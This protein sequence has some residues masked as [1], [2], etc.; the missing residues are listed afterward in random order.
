M[1]ACDVCEQEVGWA[2]SNAS[3]YNEP[4]PGKGREPSDGGVRTKASLREAADPEG[5]Q[6]SQ[7]EKFIPVGSVKTTQSRERLSVWGVCGTRK[8]SKLNHKYN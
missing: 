6:T 5:S 2:S 4:L 1:A 8:L 7:G 3:L